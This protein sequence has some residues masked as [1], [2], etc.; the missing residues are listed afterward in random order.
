MKG[1]QAS[2]RSPLKT[3]AGLITQQRTGPRPSGAVPSRNRAATIAAT[4]PVAYAS[5][6]VIQH[7]SMLL[8]LTSP[9]QSCLICAL[10]HAS[11]TR[12]SVQEFAPYRIP[13]AT[14][15]RRYAFGFR[16]KGGRGTGQ[17]VLPPME[18]PVT[19]KGQ[20]GWDLATDSKAAAVLQCT[21]VAALI[22]PSCTLPATDKQRDRQAGDHLA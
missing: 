20:P 14:R 8:M 13:Q 17:K 4:P 6:V 16:D 21:N 2:D 9:L 19:T 10:L 7:T 5:T 12:C 22:M 11:S 15:T 1:R 18:W 3:A